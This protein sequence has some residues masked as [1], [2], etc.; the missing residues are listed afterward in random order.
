MTRAIIAIGLCAFLAACATH[1]VPDQVSGTVEKDI[2]VAVPCS[3][4]AGPAPDF[5][6]TDFAIAAT[7][8]GDIFG[9]AR[10]YAA[11]RPQRLAYIAKLEAANAGCAP[12]P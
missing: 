6:D 2:P 1:P 4:S 3:V 11:G 9:L 12:K 7:P 8:K 10:L 5:A